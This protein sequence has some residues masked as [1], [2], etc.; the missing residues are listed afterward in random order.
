MPID[1]CY[2]DSFQACPYRKKPS[3]TF[4]STGLLGLLDCQEPGSLRLSLQELSGPQ[5]Q[6]LRA[7][8]LAYMTSGPTPAS[9]RAE[10]AQENSDRL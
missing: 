7:I 1:A 10:P 8:L 9:V 5:L 2:C 4:T 3:F 6:P